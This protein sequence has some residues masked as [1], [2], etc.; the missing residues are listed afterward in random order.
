MTNR[1]FALKMFLCMQGLNERI[2]WQ[3]FLNSIFYVGKAKSTRPYSH[4]Y[5]AIKKYNKLVTI[6]KESDDKG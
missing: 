4:L 5:N 3:Q 1:L 6:I 2:I